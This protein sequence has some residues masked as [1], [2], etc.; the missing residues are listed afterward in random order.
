MMSTEVYPTNIP[1]LNIPSERI[2]TL[3][4]L[5]L[6]FNV[7]RTVDL[8]YIMQDLLLSCK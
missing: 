7:H 5:F 4:G 6:F 8:G 1:L 2:I 3:E